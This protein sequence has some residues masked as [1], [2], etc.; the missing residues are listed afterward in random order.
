LQ[1]AVIEKL[2][3]FHG[4]NPIHTKTEKDVTLH[5]DV[6]NWLPEDK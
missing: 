6:K 4:Q 3:I 2:S 1:N 5:K